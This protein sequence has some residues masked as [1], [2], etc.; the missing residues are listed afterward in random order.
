[1]K[2]LFSKIIFSLGIVLMAS[3]LIS[4]YITSIAIQNEGNQ[5]G[6]QQQ[7]QQQQNQ[8]G[9]QQQNQTGQQQ[10]NQTGQQQQNQT[11][12]QQGQQAEGG[13]TNTVIIPQ[14]ASSK[15]ALQK[16]Y[17]PE[18]ITVSSGNSI[19][20][21]NKD[22]AAHTATARDGSFD[23]GLIQSQNSASVTLEGQGNLDYYCTIHPWMTGSISFQQK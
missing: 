11:G 4:I 7:G 19:T 12:Q 16:Y 13:L 2:P 14:G 5:T 22:I 17:N 20:W 9:Q 23:T 6:Q 1:M 21:D 15:G 3:A 10:Q 8:T 18:Q